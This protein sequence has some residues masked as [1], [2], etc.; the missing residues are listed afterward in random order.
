MF[1]ALKPDYQNFKEKKHFDKQAFL[2]DEFGMSKN[3][4]CDGPN[5]VSFH[6]SKVTK[7]R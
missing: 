2:N 3:A 5:T 4:R 6:R 7:N 1:N